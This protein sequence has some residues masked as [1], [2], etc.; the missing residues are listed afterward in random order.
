MDKISNIIVSIECSLLDSLK[1]LNLSEF[2]IL[3]L[4]DNEGKLVKTLTDGDIR[5]FILE[6]GKLNA[7]VGDVSKNNPVVVKSDVSHTEVLKLMIKKGISQ[8]PILDDV[9]RPI[10][11]HIQ[12]DLDKNILLSTP[13]MGNHEQ[14][15]V[16]QAFDSNWIAPTGPN[17]DA[18]EEEISKY[19]GGSHVAV[20]NSGTSAIHLSLVLLNISQG[21]FVFCQ[22]FTFIASV[23]PILYQAAIPVFI[24]SEAKT[25]NMCPIALRKALE[26]HKSS[27]NLPKAIIVVHLYGLSA[28]MKE[29][30]S[31]ANEYNIPVIEDA[32]ESVGSFYKGKHTGT[33]GKFGIFSF[34]G[35]KIITTSGGGA[36]VS[37]DKKLI[38]KAR[39]LSTQA[40]DPRPHYEHSNIGYN[41]RM[42]N[43]LAGI[44]RGQLK[45]LNERVSSRQ[46]ILE[47]YK[48]S[49]KM[50]DSIDWIPDVKGN[51]SNSWLSVLTINP[52]KTSITA[53]ILIEALLMKNIEARHVWK[54]MHQQPLFD[55]NKYYTA[56][57]ES[58]SDYLFKT[59][60]CLPSSSNISVH[61][62]DYV[63]KNIIEVFSK[64]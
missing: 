64:S 24:D 22:S 60:V 59:G 11:I 4:V 20:V 41:Y 58:F 32:A 30:L 26:E 12:K 7:K 56:V 15:F 48:K 29:I 28:S 53:K 37:H 57:D 18:F 44:G 21:D 3:L 9:G 31:I 49:L 19:V 55:K 17:V 40:K 35:N 38:E 51:V 62:Q 42:S 1:I 61:Q 33:L 36:L 13:H 6:K 63:I 2:L 39:F 46:K 47:K 45:V 27:N 52:K 43:V 23:N 34:N 25:W 10:G 50:I 54:P 5:R 14:K 16:K 8:I